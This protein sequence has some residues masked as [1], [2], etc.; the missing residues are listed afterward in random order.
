MLISLLETWS[1]TNMYLN[2]R[3]KE[4]LKLEGTPMIIESNFQ[5]HTG[6]PKNQGIRGSGVKKTN[7]KSS[8]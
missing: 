7:K 6:P 2:H 8:F 3:I 4:Y 5:L 1:I